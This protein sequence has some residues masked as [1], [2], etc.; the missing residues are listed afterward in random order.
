MVVYDVVG[1]GAVTEL[2]HLPHL[3][4]LRLEKK[5]DIRYWIDTSLERASR[6]ARRLGSGEPRDS[7]P[8]DPEGASVALIATPPSTHILLAAP[9]V[10]AS[11]VT[12]IEKPAVVSLAEFTALYGLSPDS[13]C[14]KVFVGNMRRLYVGCRLARKAIGAGA[15]G[16]VRAVQVSEGGRWSWGAQSSY[17]LSDMYG[18]VLWD[19]GAHALD[20]ALFLLSLDRNEI[21]ISDVR[22]ERAPA[23]GP[24]H[25]VVGSFTLEGAAFS[26][27]PWE[28]RLSRLRPLFAGVRIIGESGTVVVGPGFPDY[29]L[30]KRG[31]ELHQLR[32]TTTSTHEAATAENAFRIEHELLLATYHGT[33]WPS[34]LEFRY[35]KNSTKLLTGLCDHG[36]PPQEDHG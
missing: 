19:T 12:L 20:T 16:E 30:I 14:N 7:L 31:T 28:V 34:D 25:E 33:A 1:C 27:L 2:Y 21:R 18:G 13:M 9:Y 6:L 8:D 15:I 17:F 35:F 11:V 29:A 5:L 22:T 26:P 36:R 4:R 10:Q 23:S 3:A 24:E 32:A